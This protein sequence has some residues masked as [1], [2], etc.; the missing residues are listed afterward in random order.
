MATDN[1]NNIKELQEDAFSCTRCNS[2][3]YVYKEYVPSCPAGNTY[4][5][6]TYFPSGK[7]QTARALLQGKLEWSEHLRDIVYSCPTC[8]SCTKQC[9]SRF[10]ERIVDVIEA[11]RAD[12]VE[13][14]F[15]PMPAHLKM[16][17]GIENAAM[18]NPYNEP[19][20]KRKQLLSDL[21]KDLPD[22]ADYAWFVGCTSSLRA[23]NLVSAT[24]RVLTKLGVNYTVAV[25][26]WCCTSPLLRT[27]QLASAREIAEHNMEV[28]KATGARAVIMNCAGC[29]R[30]FIRDYEKMG[31][32]PDDFEVLHVTEVIDAFLTKN[33]AKSLAK[34]KQAEKIKVTYHDPC[35]LGRHVGVFD[36]PRNILQKISNY[37]LVEMKR[38]RDNAWCCGSGGGVK[39]AFGEWALDIGK[40]RLLEAAST[41]AEAIVSACPFC[42]RNLGDVLEKFSSSKAKIAKVLDI[43]ELLDN[44][45]A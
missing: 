39:S 22:T 26:E 9:A 29:Y 38:N 12:A 11:L 42:E 25:D 1:L 20:E 28:L 23:Q 3:K 7:M 4:R 10:H 19:A 18:R 5:W 17:Q 45:L 34:G 6:E 27:G 14:G 16:K 41:D 40:E 31:L 8:G 36:A 21:K 2:C 43:V 32:L 24:N 37:Q 44:V 30:T 33:K 15:G 35:H 13:S